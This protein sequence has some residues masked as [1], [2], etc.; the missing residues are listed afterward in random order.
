MRNLFFICVLLLACNQADKKAAVPM[1]DSRHSQG[2]NQSVD[3]VMSAYEQ[4]TVAFVNWDSAQLPVLATAVANSLQQLKMA[5]RQDS[6]VALKLSEKFLDSSVNISQ[7]IRNSTDIT[8]QRHSLNDLSDNLLNFLDVVQY[9]RR[10]L[11]LQQ[12][13]M[14]FNDTDTG[15]WISQADS[16]RNPYLGLHHPRYG[17]GMLECGETKKVLDHTGSK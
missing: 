17:K 16:I 15:L 2:F 12:C 11:Y 1:K 14:A 4:L 7:R 3:A 8:A 9:D 13:P 10:R 6:T 5:A